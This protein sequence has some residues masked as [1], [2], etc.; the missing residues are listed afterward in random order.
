MRDLFA[1]NIRP[2]FF[3]LPVVS[4]KIGRDKEPKLSWVVTANCAIWTIARFQVLIF[5][6]N[7]M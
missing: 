5:K 1:Q 6:P 3:L 2:M 7:L 4:P